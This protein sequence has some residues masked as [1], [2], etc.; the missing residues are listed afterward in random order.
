MR[1]VGKLSANG[2]G[3]GLKLD[4]INL[5]LFEEVNKDDVF[6]F[7]TE[8]LT[9]PSANARC[10]SLCPSADD[11]QLKQMRLAGCS[12]REEVDALLKGLVKE[13]S[14]E[15]LAANEKQTLEQ[16]A[17]YLACQ[18]ASRISHA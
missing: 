15:Q 7:I 12:R 3:G 4:D 11:S 1:L 13:T 8:A 14:A 16:E 2:S 17:T 9:L 5:A 6:R 18:L 10:F